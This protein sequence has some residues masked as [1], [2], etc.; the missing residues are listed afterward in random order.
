MKKTVRHPG[1]RFE[2]LAALDRTHRRDV[3]DYEWSAIDLAKALKSNRY[4]I[5]HTLLKLARYDLVE[6]ESVGGFTDY[7]RPLKAGGGVV[8]KLPNMTLIWRLT[9]RGEERL[10]YVG[11]HE[12]WCVLCPK[13]KQK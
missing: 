5:A 12:R 10:A 7:E 2:I 9:K 4:T 8:V 1:R 11:G 13:G 6:G 3:G